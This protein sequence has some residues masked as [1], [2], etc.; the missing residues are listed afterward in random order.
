MTAHHYAMPLWLVRMEC[1]GAKAVTIAGA[2]TGVDDV[3]GLPHIVVWLCN[4]ADLPALR[5]V[6]A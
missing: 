5:L 4:V 3:G 2:R 6:R 1:Q